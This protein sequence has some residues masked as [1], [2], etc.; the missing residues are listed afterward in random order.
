M[1][2]TLFLAA[3]IG[4]GQVPPDTIEAFLRGGEQHVSGYRATMEYL[5][6]RLAVYGNGALPRAENDG[7]L[8]SGRGVSWSLT[9]GLRAR[10]GPI[11]L[12]LA[13]EVL[14][15]QNAPFEIFSAET[16]SRSTFSS[17]FHP[18]GWNSLDLPL[19]MGTRAS[20]SVGPGASGV[21]AEFAD[22]SVVAGVTA[23]P[24]WWGP[25]TKNA[26]LLSHQAPGVPRLFAS[27]RHRPGIGLVEWNWF[28]GVVTESPFFD[29]DPSNDRRSLGGFALAFTP[30]VLGGVTVGGG[31]L[32]LMPWRGS[33]APPAGGVLGLSFR[34]GAL[35][36]PDGD[37]P[38]VDALTMLFVA[39]SK[40]EQ[41]VR[42]GVEAAWQE[43]PETL[44]DWLTKWTHT[45]AVTASFGWRAPPGTPGDGWYAQGEHT[46]LDQ[47][48]TRFDEPHPPDFYSGR[49][50][51]HGFTH[52]G[53]LLGALAGPG[54]QSL[55]VEVGRRVATE[56]EVGVFGARSRFENDAAAR[57]QYFNFTRRDVAIEGGARVRGRASG[58]RADLALGLQQRLNYLFQNGQGNPLGLRTIDVLNP[59]LTLS[60]DWTWS[61]R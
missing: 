25:S 39:W 50:D 26:L 41:G 60:L 48:R 35:G 20:G 61:D 24:A 9:S 13:P 44:D 43:P 12:V 40:P 38:A 58:L 36:T 15:S 22:G 33:R 11:V 59:F 46:S 5:P 18:E 51:A 34:G 54:G 53:Q 52:R 14:W 55:W 42:F 3:A 31:H 1:V 30:R 17:P 21:F 29:R 16:D 45:R 56:I 27:G 47:T 28:T 6:A 2:P 7:A 49:A 37:P 23:A 19:R 32:A 10:V 57:Q 8:W 4:A